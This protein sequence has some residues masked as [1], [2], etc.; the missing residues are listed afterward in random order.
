MSEMK[1]YSHVLDE[2]VEWGRK[3]LFR[4]KGGKEK[5]LQIPKTLLE[6]VFLPLDFCEKIWGL[7]P[8]GPT[9]PNPRELGHVTGILCLCLYARNGNILNSLLAL[10]Q[11]PKGRKNGLP[12]I[13]LFF[14][15]S[16]LVSLQQFGKILD[17]EIIFN[18]RGSK[19]S[20]VSVPA[21]L[22]LIAE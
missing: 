21:S 12:K 16:P 2:I 11:P 22:V 3:E 10:S 7:W 1:S 6:I 20:P 5:L 13:N 19:V 14:F 9:C 17:V 8:R 15:F 18:E 4:L